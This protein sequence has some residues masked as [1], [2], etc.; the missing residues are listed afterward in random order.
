MKKIFAVL[1]IAGVMASCGSKK[2]DVK[3]GD[4]DTT[5]TT[6]TTTTG[7][8]TTTTTT[9]TTGVPTFSDPEIQKLVTDYDAFISAYLNGGYKDP[10]KAAEYSKSMQD[11]STRMQGVSVKLANNPD[12]LKKWTDYWTA[13]GK[14]IQDATMNM[15]K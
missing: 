10:A 13:M 11:W 12:D 4:N 7:D 1:A 15:Y 8:K 14:K 3:K 5:V 9:T 2:K 6:N